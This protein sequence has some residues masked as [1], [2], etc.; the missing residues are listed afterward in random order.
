MREHHYFKTRRSVSLEN[1]ENWMNLDVQL[2]KPWNA[3]IK[4][5]LVRTVPGKEDQGLP[6]LQRRSSS[7]VPASEINNSWQ[8]WCSRNISMSTVWRVHCYR[9]CCEETTTDR[10]LEE[11]DEN[12]LGRG[13]QGTDIRPNLYFGLMKPNLRFLVP[14]ALCDDEKGN[15]W[16]LRV[17]FSPWSLE[18]V[19]WCEGALLVTLFA[20]YSKL[21]AHFISISTSAFC[22]EMPSHLV[23]I[24]FSIERWPQSHFQAV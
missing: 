24:C 17:W 3:M 22:S 4:L 5:A 21:K 16:Y 14:I 12:H 13:T 11:E 7:E 8:N 19:W 6:L 9:P 23:C 10:G 1:C 15:G 2:Q 18:E 20:I